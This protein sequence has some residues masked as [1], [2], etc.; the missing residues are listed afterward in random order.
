[1]KEPDNVLRILR[2]TQKSIIRKE[3][4][5]LKHLSNQTIN[6]A[7]RT[8]DPDNILLAVVVYALG[9]IYERENYHELPGWNKYKQ[10]LDSSLSKAVLAMEKEKH[11]EAISHL[12]LM[13]DSV[14]KLSGKLKKYISD[15]FRRASI[16]KASRMHEHGISMERTAKLLGVTMWELADYVGETGIADVKENISSATSLKGRIKLAMEMFE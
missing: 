14:N 6:T 15:V 3:Y 7:S 2:E 11:S 4:S 10:I 16:N 12:E 8:H 9:K 13:R 1:M 5:R